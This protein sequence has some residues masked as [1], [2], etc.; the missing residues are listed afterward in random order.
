MS[1]V[2]DLT[3]RLLALDTINP[4][5]NE[6]PAARLLGDLLSGAGFEA[7]YFEFAPSRTTL[8]AT[9][10]GEGLPLAFTGHVDTVPLGSAAWRFD[11]FRGDID[12]DLLFGRGTSDMKGAVAAMVVAALAHARR[13]APRAGITLI[14]TAGEDTTCQGATYLARAM[15]LRGAAGALVVG[16]PTSLRPVTAHKGCVRYRVE[17]AGV[18]AHGSMP[19]RGVNAIHR[20]AEV[21]TAL[22]AFDFGIAAHP[23]L[24]RPTLNIG[25]IQG[26]SSI[27]TVADAAEIGVDIRLLPGQD[28]AAVRQQL[29][30]AAGDGVRIELLERADSVETDP[31]HPWILSVCEM[32]GRQL[33][34]QA[35][36]S[37]VPYFTDASVLKAALGHPPTIILGP[38]EAAMAHKTDEYC[39]VSLLERAVTLYGEIAAAWQPSRYLSP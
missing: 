4:P 14:I 2:V 31:G 39:R 28:E 17:T 37:G 22:R 36:P 9:L 34:E 29:L 33:G 15:D 5:G 38:G 35:A 23:L 21:I 10:P 25:T 7:S 18:A 3:R 16:E 8:M 12:G 27:N 30:A 19:E 26:G 32:A 24:G 1:E 6:F 13:P 20:M 11:P